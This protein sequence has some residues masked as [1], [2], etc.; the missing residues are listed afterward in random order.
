MQRR[1]GLRTSS[2]FVSAS[3][4][5]FALGVAG[6]ALAGPPLWDHVVVV[7]EE[8]HSQTSIISDTPITSTTDG[9]PY[10]NELATGGVRFN[11]MYALMH[12]SQPNYLELFSGSNQN[13]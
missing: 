6:Q 5:V 1:T 12:P 8:N 10:I 4:A 13:I 7:I 9:A 2:A 3:A 11:N